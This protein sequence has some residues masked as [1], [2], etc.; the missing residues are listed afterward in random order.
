MGNP[1]IFLAVRRPLV[2]WERAE[3]FQTRHEVSIL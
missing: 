2:L 1:S 3:V